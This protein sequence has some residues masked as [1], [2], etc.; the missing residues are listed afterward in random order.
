MSSDEVVL[1]R[2]S[3]EHLLRTRDRALN[4]LA[5]EKEAAEH[6]RQWAHSQ[7]VEQRRLADRLNE[8]CTAAAA[9]GVPITAINE[10]LK[11]AES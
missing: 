8:V 11:K 7:F 9:L 2:K 3:Y 6:A 1:K 10:A 4:Q 5:W